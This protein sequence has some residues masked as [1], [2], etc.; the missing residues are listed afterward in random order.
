MSTYNNTWKTSYYGG[1]LAYAG[2]KLPSD[3]ID[4]DARNGFFVGQDYDFLYKYLTCM[5]KDRPIW[6]NTLT[7]ADIK[8][9]T[10]S[11]LNYKEDLLK[12][13]AQC[14]ETF[15]NRAKDIFGNNSKSYTYEEAL[16]FILMWE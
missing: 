1:N 4:A 12:G 11:M 9:A 7:S 10:S 6:W 15:Q 16:S 5:G 14:W 2:A 3:R 13:G 8:S